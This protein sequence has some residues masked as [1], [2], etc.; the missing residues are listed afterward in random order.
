[1]KKI[2]LLTVLLGFSFYGFSQDIK[3]AKSSEK[4][5][6]TVKVLEKWSAS[7]GVKYGIRGGYTIS[8]RF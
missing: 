6:D 2:L 5:K 7:N 3:E 8:H 1:M 4:V